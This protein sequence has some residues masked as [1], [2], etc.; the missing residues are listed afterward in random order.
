[1]NMKHKALIGTVSLL[2]LSG[3]GIGTAVASTTRT[4]TSPPAV[5]TPSTVVDLP[6]ANEPNGPDTDNVQVGP[7]TG[8][9]TEKPDVAETPEANGDNHQD[10]PG[11]NV[12]NTPPGEQPE[13]AG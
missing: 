5:T 13:A 2:G 11:A 8:A 4:P 9:D 10:A 6:G 1:M 12:D 7:Q 3:I